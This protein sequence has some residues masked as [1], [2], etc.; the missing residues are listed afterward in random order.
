MRLCLINNIPTPYI[1]PL[2]NSVNR[3]P[4]VSLHAVFLSGGDSNRQWHGDLDNA[5]FSYTVL[6]GFS[7]FYRKYDLPIYCTFGLWSVFKKHQTDVACICGYHYLAS[8]EVLL[9]AMF[10][11]IK[12][13]LWSGSHLESGQFR[14]WLTDQY[15]KL[16]IRRFD[17]FVTYGTASRDMLLHYGAPADRVSVGFNAVDTSQYSPRPG[18]LES[19]FL[20]SR[21][22]EMRVL[23][24]G[25]LI[26]RKGVDVLIRAA[27]FLRREKNINISLTI[28]GNGPDRNSLQQLAETCGLIDIRFVGHQPAK[29][30]IDYYRACDVFVLPSRKE[31]WGLVVNEAMASGLPVVA[32]QQAGASRDLVLDGCNGFTYEAENWQELAEH[33]HVLAKDRDFRKKM[34]RESLRIISTKGCDAYAEAIIRACL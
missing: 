13:V 28:V 19:R 10:K 34:G 26:P 31:V 16:I 25:D 1:V 4:E 12:A 2:F 29:A 18:D 30:I 20:D 8:I 27:A 33:L 17:S 5:E 15:K 11:N 6:S 14:N 7:A 22:D 32:S 21:R 3:H 24:V 9:Y 23:F